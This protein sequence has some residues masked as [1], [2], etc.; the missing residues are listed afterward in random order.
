MFPNKMASK[1]SFKSI[2]NDTIID[3][4]DVYNIDKYIKQLKDK[5]VINNFPLKLKLIATSEFNTPL[6]FDIIESHYSHPVKVI[7]T[8]NNLEKFYDG[9]TDGFK[10]WVDCF[11]ERGSGFVFR[12]IKSVEVKQYKYS[13]QKASSYIPLQFKSTNIINVQNTN[14]NQCFLW[15]I[16]AK[17]F[18]ANR[19]K[20]RVTN[21]IQYEDKLNM[22]G[23]EYP[24]SIDDI[25]KVERL[26]P[27]LSINVYAL[28]NQTNKESLFPV[29]VSNVESND[30]FDLLY[31]ESNQNTHYCL[32][33]DL[34]SFRYDKNKHKQYTC[35][36]CLQGFQRKE[37]MEKHKEICFNHKHCNTI[38][39]KKG[40]NDVL[41][42]KNHQFQER[43]PFAIYCDFEANNIPIETSHPNPSESYTNKMF[44]QEVNSYG[45]Y[46]KSHY[47]DI[48]KSQYFSYIGK[49]AKEK[50]V[51]TIIKI[52]KNI[53][54]RLYLNEK[55]EPMLTKQEEDEFQQA[56][57]CYI[58]EKEL[59]E[60]KIREHNHLT[61]EYRGAACQSCNT[62]EGKSS[63]LIPV[64]FHNGS[65]YD[66][67]FIIE[68]LVKYEDEYNKVS[69]L[70][71]NSE[72]YI[73]IEYGSTYKKLRFL[74]SY[75]FF[76]KGLAN[77]AKSLK[78]FPILESEFNEIELLKEKGVYPYEYIDSIVRLNDTELPSKDKFYSTLKQEGI[79]DE[80]YQ[81]A[82]EVWNTFNCKT[83][84]D[85]HNLYLKTDVL[86]L[87]DAF[88]QFRDFFLHYHNIDPCYCFSAPGLTWQCGLRYTDI[89]LELLTDYDMLLMFEKGIR[90]GFSGVLGPRHV[91]AFNKYTPNYRGN[92]NRILDDHEMKE[93]MERLKR[94]ENLND[95]LTEK[96][97][98]YLDANNLYGWAMSQK[99]PTRDFKWE[100]NE[101][102]YKDI[103]EGRGCLVECDLEYPDKFKTRKYPLA[104]EHMAATENMLS[105]YQLNLLEKQN[106][107]LG[108]EEKLFL[109]L[110]DKKKYV[111]HHS[112]LKYYIKLGLKVTK[113]HRI[114]SFEET[115]WLKSY[116]DFN[117]QQRTK[118]KSDFEKDLWKLMNNA[119][120][121]K[122]MENI[123]NRSEIKLLSNEDE[124]K[125]YINKPNFKDSIIFNENLIAIVNNIT[126][127][128]FNKPIY[129][130]QAILD[131]SKQLMYKF[132]YE[133][134]EE[135]WPDNELVASDTDSIFLSVK[136][137]DIYEDMKQII[138]ELDTSDY[139]E[140]YSLHSKVNKKVI[141]K[142]KDEL[143]GKIMSEIVF[144]RSKAYA[145]SLSDLTE[146][147]KLKG[148]SQTTVKKD[149][150]LND[151]KNCLFNNEIQLNKMYRL[152]SEKHNMYINEV[153]KVSLNPFDDK[154]YICEDG[155]NTLP[156]GLYTFI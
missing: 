68:E 55:K 15:S 7:Q 70:S 62:K 149:I 67:H 124:I 8:K 59:K 26:N 95:F 78:D 118:S 140:D 23:I 25:P 138:Q 113:V 106:T 50:F 79:T 44:K 21:Y 20:Q 83:L 35:R 18:P 93:C 121:G 137:K 39:P 87:A 115:N 92:G 109:T 1:K 101:D 133:V 5:I 125:K 47:P 19:N 32:I 111:V 52:Y 97:L 46:V 74:D 81:H 9:F 48:Y 43:L 148:I 105:D 58:C 2:I 134:V 128:K 82:Q 4:I 141:G 14:D 122:T 71:K 22:S 120:F 28:N 100:A 64:F 56:T 42:F 17:S 88:E 146:K 77:V 37:T 51:K 49:D 30:R 72:E 16:L 76:Q 116:I 41:K 139:P 130:G 98:L 75:R 108:K 63:K 143:N 135:L 65:N 69:P 154:R 27:G 153:N 80:E 132:Y 110:Y 104:P 31:I 129:L 13:Y 142:F 152:N 86:I 112:I 103:P 99:L 73:S 60:H 155:I 131:Y 34:D 144:L 91:K 61:G 57:S 117:T 150:T 45:I 29:H 6:A 102:Y 36:N 94:G 66:F 54:Y 11:Q 126:S 127:I 53:T 84:K 107:K 114:I 10:A 96:F 119:F 145:Y 3:D 24:V 90:G 33:K 123:R 38:M 136:T 156:F 151:Y 85:Y 147:K 12:N 40:K 89:Q